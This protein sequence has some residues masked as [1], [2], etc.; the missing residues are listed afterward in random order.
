M[1]KNHPY[2]G[3]SMSTNFPGSLHT[4][5]FVAFSRTIRN[6][7]GNPCISHMTKYAIGW[8]SNGKEH[9]YHGKSMSTNFPDFPHTMGFVLF[10]RTVGNLLGNPYNSHVMTLVNFFLYRKKL[11]DVII[12]FSFYVILPH[13]GNAG[14][15]SFISHN[16]GKG[17]QTH[18]MGECLE[19]WLPVIS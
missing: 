6:W 19:N 13:M 4:R 5:G 12:R 11:T 18:R 8:E 3:K 14:V 16:I 2:Y 15:F 17:S 10:S 1:G 9:P 7:W